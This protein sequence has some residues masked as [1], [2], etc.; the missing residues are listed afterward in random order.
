MSG[1]HPRR[2]AGVAVPL[3]D[4]IEKVTGR[5]L[6]TADLVPA[7]ALTARILRS[8]VGHGRIARLDVSRARQLPGVMAVVTG[9]DCDQ[10]YGVLPIA[11][12]EYPLARGRVRYRGEPVA[13]VAAMDAQT[14]QRA[15]DLI[16]VSRSTNCRPTTASRRRVPPMRCCCTTTGRATSNARCITSSAMSPQALPPPTSCAKSASTTPR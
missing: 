13:A 4:G 1:P 10:P 6:F 3:V 15:L 16:D 8:P 2:T 9:E 14:A 12:N 5:A 11:M 7:D